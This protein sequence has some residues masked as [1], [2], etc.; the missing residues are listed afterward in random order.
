MRSSPVPPARNSEKRLGSP[1]QLASRPLRHEP[2]KHGYES[3]LRFASDS[4]ISSASSLASMEKSTEFLTQ[5][6]HDTGK[7]ARPAQGLGR[8]ES[9][10]VAQMTAALAGIR[11]NS[12]RIAR[13]WRAPPAAAQR[14]LPRL[15]SHPALNVP[16]HNRRTN[17]RGIPRYESRSVAEMTAGLD[18][19]RLNSFSTLGFRAPPAGSSPEISRPTLPEISRPTPPE[20]SRPLSPPARSVPEH[21]RPTEEG[22]RSDSNHATIGS[23]P[24]PPVASALTILAKDI[25]STSRQPPIPPTVNLMSM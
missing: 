22:V 16:Q 25:L 17:D 8:H 3:R 12:F 19:I 13:H 11:L 2:Y 7:Q 9:R 18:G 24:S 5:M 4:S 21:T 1:F 10:S 6:N 14:D 20:I 15:P 23:K